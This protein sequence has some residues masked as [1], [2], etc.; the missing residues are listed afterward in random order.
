MPR[1]TARSPATTLTWRATT[2]R[3]AACLV[4]A[5]RGSWPMRCDTALW[6]SGGKDS[7]ACLYLLR[8]RLSEIAVLWANTGKNYPELLQTVAHAKAMC[9]HFIEVKT[10]R[11]AQWREHGIAS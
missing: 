10:D 1:I 9:P 8:D 6:F 2:A 4:L 3:Q 5:P 11:D 7:M